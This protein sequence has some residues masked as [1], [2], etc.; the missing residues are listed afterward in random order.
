M[1]PD[2]PS[3]NGKTVVGFVEEVVIHDRAIL[4]RI[5]TGAA[6]SSI[7]L[8]LASELQLGPLVAKRTVI[9]ASGKGMRPVVKASVNIGNR[10]IRASFTIIHRAHMEYPVLIGR[11]ILKKDFLIDPSLPVPPKRTS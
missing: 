10:T 9:S 6:T 11:N 5:D 3:L 4:A 2:K 8:G 7:D 1:R